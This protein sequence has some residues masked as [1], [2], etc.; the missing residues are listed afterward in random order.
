MPDG[1]DVTVPVPV[2]ALATFRAKLVPVGG[3]NGEGK[4]A[5]EG[6][7]GEA[8]PRQ[9]NRH[10]V[11]AQRLLVQH[12]DVVLLASGEVDGRRPLRRVFG[13]FAR[14]RP[15]LHEGDPSPAGRVVARAEP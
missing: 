3:T 7:R 15:A 14:V 6:G 9:G 13:P 11:T 4:G 8:G 12:L 10:I 1:E 5:A 2:P